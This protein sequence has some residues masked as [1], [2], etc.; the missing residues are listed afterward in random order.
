[1][2]SPTHK[3]DASIKDK[4]TSRLNIILPKDFHK[5]VKQRALDEDITVTEL[6]YKAVKAYLEK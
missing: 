3:T 6:I 5:K 2:T 4:E 1:M